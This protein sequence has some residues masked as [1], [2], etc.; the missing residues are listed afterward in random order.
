MP[1][2]GAL[3]WHL[4]G[5]G[6]RR[7]MIAALQPELQPHVKYIFVSYTQDDRPWADWIAWQL[8][9]AG[10]EVRYQGRDFR[11]GASFM[12]AMQQAVTDAATT[13]AVLSPA[14]LASPFCTAEW[15]AA[16]AGDPTNAAGRLVPVRVAGGPPPGLLAPLAFVD[17][18]GADDVEAAQRLRA[19]VGASPALRAALGGP[20]VPARPRRGPPLFPPRRLQALAWRLAGAAAGGTGVA[21]GVLDFLTRTMPERAASAPSPLQITAGACGLVAAAAIYAVMNWLGA[22]RRALAAA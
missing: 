9:A 18:V 2:A 1:W 12:A 7:T 22:R 4:R 11:Q 17:L 8:E 5:V 19:G 13:V 6:T 20:P 3:G 21:V 10:Y 14:Y 15:T 16:M